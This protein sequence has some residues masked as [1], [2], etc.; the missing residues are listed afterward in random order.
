MQSEPTLIIKNPSNPEKSQTARHHNQHGLDEDELLSSLLSSGG[1]LDDRSRSPR[2]AKVAT[3]IAVAPDDGEICLQD[4]PN[5]SGLKFSN[6]YK[7]Y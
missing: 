4:L 7:S 6:G 3:T 2:G 1:G 5:G